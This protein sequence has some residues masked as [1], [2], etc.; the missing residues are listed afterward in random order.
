[1][2]ERLLTS[3]S[4]SL[5]FGVLSAMCPRIKP[6]S[7]ATPTACRIS[8][9]GKGLTARLSGLLLCAFEMSRCA[10]AA[11]VPVPKERSQKPTARMVRWLQRQGV[12]AE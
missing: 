2:L 3:H 1:M 5:S 12:D 4:K 10:Y 11:S 7:A 9:L 6:A 8:L